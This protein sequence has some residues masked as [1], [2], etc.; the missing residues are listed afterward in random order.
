MILTLKVT[1]IYGPHANDWEG[2]FEIDSSSP[3]EELRYAIQKTVD[4]DDDHLYEFYMARSVRSRKR[5][6]IDD[7]IESF[8]EVYLKDIFP[9]PD[10]Q[11]LF[12]FYDFGDY[13]TFKITKTRAKMHEPNPDLE[14]PRLILESGKRPVQY[15]STTEEW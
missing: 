2:V 7:N 1:L 5:T 12:Y 11:T 4:F 15:P 8:H 10:R 13:W 14:Y 3:L 9:L 6:R